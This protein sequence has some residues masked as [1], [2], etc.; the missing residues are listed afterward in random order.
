MTINIIKLKPLRFILIAI[1]LLLA[2]SLVNQPTL[3]AEEGDKDKIS[4]SGVI[5]STGK[6]IQTWSYKS[7]LFPEATV[8]DDFNQYCQDQTDYR[9]IETDERD[10]FTLYGP[11]SLIIKF[12]L[13]DTGHFF[14][15]KATPKYEQ[16][17]KEAELYYQ[18]QVPG[19]EE[20]KELLDTSLAIAVETK[21]VNNK[22]L[23]DFA[24]SFFGLQVFIICLGSLIGILAY[25]LIRQNK[26]DDLDDIKITKFK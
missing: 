26:Q 1:G 22:S 15:I 9:T 2:I 25:Q 16:G 13:E 24:Q 4:N 8:S 12:D 3:S 10:R 5:L 21:I 6:I 17:D 7:K 23:I 11:D 20:F 14:C 19:A 18:H